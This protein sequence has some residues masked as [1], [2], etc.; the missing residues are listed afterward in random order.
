MLDKAIT[1]LERYMMDIYMRLKNQ[2]STCRE[3]DIIRFHVA[4]ASLKLL[5]G[6]D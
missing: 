4:D 1:A 2:T 3:D 6:L 5:E